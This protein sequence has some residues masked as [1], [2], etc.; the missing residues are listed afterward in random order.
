VV[1]GL[2]LALAPFSAFA[3]NQG[4]QEAI[5]AI[6]A[7]QAAFANLTPVQ[8]GVELGQGEIANA[9]A[10]A[11]LLSWDSHAQ[12][13]V[14]NTMQQYAMFCDTAIAHVNAQM[15]NANAMAMARP[16]DLHAQAEMANANALSHALWDIIG[17]TYAGNPYVKTPGGPAIGDDAGYA[18]ASD[19]EAVAASDDEMV[20]SDEDVAVDAVADALD[21]STD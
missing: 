18:V 7:Q 13:R 12:S 14:P 16:W 17:T 4:N 9:Q 8:Q 2:L 5:D 10:I 15:A 1:F 3:D 6:K 19:D 21:V 20:A 11:K